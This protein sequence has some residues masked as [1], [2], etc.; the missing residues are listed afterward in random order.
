M[1]EWQKSYRA[2][3]KW[4]KNFR[5][6]RRKSM[7]IWLSI[8]LSLGIAY[9]SGITVFDDECRDSEDCRAFRYDRKITDQTIIREGYQL[10]IQNVDFSEFIHSRNRARNLAQYP[11]LPESFRNDYSFILF[12]PEKSKVFLANDANEYFIQDW[13][14][15]QESLKQKIELPVNP[16]K[17]YLDLRDFSNFSSKNVWDEN[18][19]TLTFYPAKRLPRFYCKKF[20]IEFVEELPVIIPETE[21]CYAGSYNY[22]GSLP[23]SPDQ[24]FKVD[25]KILMAKNQLNEYE[26]IFD[27][28]ELFEAPQSVIE[29]SHWVN[30]N[31]L[32]ISRYEWDFAGPITLLKVEIHPLNEL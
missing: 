2:F 9:P 31:I 22:S 29:T 13:L 7:K 19:L 17:D 20:R 1:N 23:I 21:D 12:N 11:H 3:I 26:T 10:Q 32:Y 24:T 15:D 6:F 16:D 30:E 18:G 8:F 14:E 5:N 4:F 25:G 27:F 28:S